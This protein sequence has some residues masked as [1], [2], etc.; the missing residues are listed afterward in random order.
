[1]YPGYFVQLLGAPPCMHCPDTHDSEH[2]T[3]KPR[4]PSVFSRWLEDGAAL[5]DQGS[6]N[7]SGVHQLTSHFTPLMHEEVEQWQL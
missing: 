6:A 2:K 5:Q 4:A 3:C 1:M 7:D